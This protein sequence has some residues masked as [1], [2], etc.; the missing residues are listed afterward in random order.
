[1]REIVYINA[2]NFSNYIGTHFFN[3]QQ[4]YL[5]DADA[6]HEDESA[7]DSVVSF[8]EGLSNVRQIISFFNP[9][10]KL[11]QFHCNRV[12]KRIAPVFSCLTSNVS[13]RT[14]DDG[15]T[16]YPFIL[17]NFGTLAKY[18]ELYTAGLDGPQV[19]SLGYALS[20]SIH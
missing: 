10:A 3:T 12:S 20:S 18:N 5:E 2:G 9:Q 15:E 4:A 7:V 1:M 19:P 8:R 13:S 6:N 14:S 11:K 17:E 16:S